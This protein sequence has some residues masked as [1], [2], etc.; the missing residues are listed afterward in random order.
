MKAAPMLRVDPAALRGLVHAMIRAGGS[1]EDEAAMVTDHLLESNLQGHDSHGIMLLV[2]YVENLRAGKLNAGAMPEAVR[3][4]ASLAVFDG[5]MGYGQRIGR[6]TMDWAINAAR[7]HGHAVMAL[8]NVHHLGRIGSYGEQAARA[9]MISVHFVNGVSGPGA[10]APFGG[11]DGRMSTNPVCVAV[12]AVSA[13]EHPLILDFATAAIALG[14][15]R[16]AFNA[17]KPVPDGALVDA[18]GK[19]T[20]DP[21]VLYRDQPRGALL[22]FGGHK[23]YGLALMCEIL[24]GALIGGVTAAPHHHKDGSIVNGWLA[25]VI[26]PA[27]FGDLAAFRSEMAAV[28][29][30]VKASPP[31]DPDQPVLVAGEKERATRAAR[32]AG[33]IPVDG[34]TWDILAD[35][36]RS[37]GINAI[38][39]P[40]MF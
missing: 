2:R 4:D 16:V 38:P 14:K 3:H 11:S 27:R 13:R 33:G 25:F 26:D 35:T 36:A 24:A 18:K 17:G 19:P 12:P 31:A 39:T 34:T 32:L 7:Q 5:K 20:N 9:G 10:V 30:H 23:G 8:K 1:A 6:I 28:I 40:G 15:C 22:P 29:A 21:G 37:L